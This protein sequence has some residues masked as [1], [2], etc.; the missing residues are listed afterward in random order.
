MQSLEAALL[1]GMR[2][3]QPNARSNTTGASAPASAPGFDK[4]LDALLQAPTPRADD[5]AAESNASDSTIQ[6]SRHAQQRMSSRGLELN[7]AEVSRLENAVDELSK[8]GAKESLVLTDERAYLVGVPKRTVITMMS[9]A[10]AMGQIFTNID[11]TFVA[12]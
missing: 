2:P 8:R 3:V 6:F 7:P 5:A 9:R 11:S 1:R 12:L 4:S 10:E